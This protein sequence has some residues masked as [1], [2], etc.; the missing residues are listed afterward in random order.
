VGIFATDNWTLSIDFAK[1]IRKENT[2]LVKSTS[3]VF[4]KNPRT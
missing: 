1:N 2:F 4:A 3:V